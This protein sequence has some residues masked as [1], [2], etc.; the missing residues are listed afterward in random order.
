MIPA[1]FYY[2]HSA[3]PDSCLSNHPEQ[4]LVHETRGVFTS[5]LRYDNVVLIDTVDGEAF[6]EGG[7]HGFREGE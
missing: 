5:D 4:L 1:D 2:T 6:G 7:A 3:F